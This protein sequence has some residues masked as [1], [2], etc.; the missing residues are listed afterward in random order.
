[1]KKSH[2]TIVST[3]IVLL[4]LIPVT[5]SAQS[6]CAAPWNPTAVYTGGMTANVNGIN[7]RANWWTQGQNPATN[8]GPAGSG[9]PWTSL[10]PCSSCK[11][12]PSVPTGLSAS[13]TTS[14]STNLKW[15]ASTAA[16]NCAITGYTVFQNGSAVG[17]ASGTSFSVFGLS[18][19]TKYTFAVAADDPAGKSG[20]SAAISVTTGS[21]GGGGGGGG[22]TFAPYNDISLAAGSQ[23]VSKAQQAGLRAISLAFMEDGGCTPVWGGLGGGINA[24][25]PNGTSVQSAINQLEANGVAVYISF[26]GA[27]GSVLSSCGSVGGAQSMFQAVVNAYHPA[28]ID[29][30]IEGGVNAPVLMSA[31]AGLKRANPRL[32]IS[33]TLP[34]LPS[35]LVTAGTNLLAAAH[36]AGFNPDVVNVMAMD[37]G[38]GVDGL[39]SGQTMGSDATMAAQNTLR[40][41][42]AAGLSSSIGVTPM[43]GVNDTNTEVFRFGDA[44]TLVGFAMGNGFITRLAFWSLGRDNGSCAGQGFASPIC[45]GVAQ[46][47]FQYSQTFE[48]FH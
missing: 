35:G 46:N 16:S 48:A 9:Q 47:N 34:V 18:A 6:G 27:N 40:Q 25:F 32:V 13:G 3:C 41:V 24:N 33:L 23:V 28:G 22:R 21:G 5:S 29:L 20:A 26:G 43:I 30:D 17:T 7:Y 2:L 4:L 38:S 39:N 44:N 11:T 14:F 10:G 12:L 1:M 42:R 36:S 45:S 8:N 37:Y 31:L 15:N 19:Q